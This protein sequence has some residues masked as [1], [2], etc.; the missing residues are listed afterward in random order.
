MQSFKFTI[1]ILCIVFSFSCKDN[2]TNPKTILP[3]RALSLSASA[4]TGTAPCDIVFTGTFNSYTDT[5]RMHFPD[6]FIIGSAGMTVIPYA[7][8]DTTVPAKRIY[9]DTLHY[10]Y[11]GSY[12]VHMLLQTT[13]QDISSDTI[14]IAVH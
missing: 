5:T 11:A 9:I 13:T 7:L 1:L 6:M 4:T 10:P 14:T 3:T 8:P 2:S 12:S